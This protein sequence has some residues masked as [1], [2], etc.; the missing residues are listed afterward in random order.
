MSTS[1]CSKRFQVC[2]LVTAAFFGAI[3]VASTVQDSCL[4]MTSPSADVA[5]CDSRMQQPPLKV[6]IMVEPSPFTYVSGYANRFQEMLRSLKAAGDTV[7]VITVDVNTD[8]PP[9]AWHDYPIHHTWGISFP[10]YPNI[11]ISI[12][13]KFQALRV[14]WR[15]RPDV[16]HVSSP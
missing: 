15:M 7:E 10:W 4:D 5:A 8:N 9:S 1:A 16:L 13:W 14:L 6:C 12:D 11:S 2:L 3:I